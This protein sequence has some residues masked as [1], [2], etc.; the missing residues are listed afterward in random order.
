M[1]DKSPQ[2][3]RRL[4]DQIAPRYDFI[5]HTLSLGLDFSWRR[6]AV[7]I[8]WNDL[9][10]EPRGP[11]LD[12]CCGTGDFSI[13]W[14][15][16]L[17]SV[18]DTENDGGPEEMFDSPEANSQWCRDRSIVVGLDFSQAM[19]DIGRQKIRKIRAEKT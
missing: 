2:T 3:I 13:A 19:L 14:S 4:F 9:R 16:K 8:V 11:I 15:R 5:N 12:V 17:V 10:H 6:R 18:D 1:L 7:E